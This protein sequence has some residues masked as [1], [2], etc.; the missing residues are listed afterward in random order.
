MIAPI[1]KEEETKPSISYKVLSLI[2]TANMVYD[3][4]ALIKLSEDYVRINSELTNLALRQQ[5]LS[6][7]K[8][9]VFLKP[10]PV[11]LALFKT[12]GIGIDFSDARSQNVLSLIKDSLSKMMDLIAEINFDEDE[13]ATYNPDTKT[14]IFKQKKI[15]ITKRAQSYA[16][17]L[18]ETLFFK[19]T[20]GELWDFYDVIKEWDQ[21]METEDI[22]E[23]E[24]ARVYQAGVSVNEKVEKKT[25][26]NDFLVITTKD[27]KIN[28]RYL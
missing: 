24:K 14:L 10:D 18:L 21:S 28:P 19:K 23:D 16:A 22:S 7:S 1:S 4:D 5:N 12:G 13:K 11:L 3:L 15:I 17:D 26:C 8:K 9:Y 27:V 6:S 2:H 20:I 25:D